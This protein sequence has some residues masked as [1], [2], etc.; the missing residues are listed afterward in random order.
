M[1]LCLSES[2]AAARRE[3]DTAAGVIKTREAA[4]LLSSKEDGE[5]L[6]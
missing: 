2:E 5:W 6:P 3:Q 4:E 1:A